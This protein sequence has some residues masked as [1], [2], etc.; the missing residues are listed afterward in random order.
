MCR[1]QHWFQS[2]LSSAVQGTFPS[3]LKMCRVCCVE[4]WGFKTLQWGLGDS[5]QSECCAFCHSHQENSIHLLCMVYTCLMHYFYV[6]NFMCKIISISRPKGQKSIQTSFHLVAVL[7]LSKPVLVKQQLI[8]CF[9]D[10]LFRCYFF[11]VSPVSEVLQVFYS[12]CCYN[13][14]QY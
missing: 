9:S 3:L 11:I 4:Y 2:Q 14:K 1:E 8:A 7:T 13:Q 12:L 6:Q 5:N 10:I